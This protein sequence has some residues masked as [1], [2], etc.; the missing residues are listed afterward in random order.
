LRD[1]LGCLL[2]GAAIGAVLGAVG[3]VLYSR[4]LRAPQLTSGG[5]RNKG[6]RLD[7]G[8]LLRLGWSIIGVIRQV[9]ALE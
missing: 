3:G 9:V 5:A 6:R 7:K 4:L 2:R 1:D 8:N